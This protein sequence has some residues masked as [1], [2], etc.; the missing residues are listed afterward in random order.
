MK[1]RVGDFSLSLTVRDGRA[2]LDFYQRAFGAE[3]LS[4]MALPDAMGGGIAH[5]EFRIGNQSLYLSEAYPD[6]NAEPM[7]DGNVA[8]C[9]FGIN[10]ENCDAAFAKALAAG[11]RP[12]DR[13]ADQPW[14][15]RTGIVVDPFGYRWNLRQFIEDVTPEE[16]TRRFKAMV[17]GGN[18]SA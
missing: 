3:E 4:R 10:V 8:S 6:W 14:G 7:E 16:L 18:T 9:L 15:F 13:P 12:I 17:G 11:A 5:A 1:P 2:A